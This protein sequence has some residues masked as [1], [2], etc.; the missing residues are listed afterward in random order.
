MVGGQKRRQR[1][2]W[3]QDTHAL[4]VS[5][6]ERNTLGLTE[7][8]STSYC[9][10][11]SLREDLNDSTVGQDIASRDGRV[12]TADFDPSSSH[13]QCLVVYCGKLLC[14]EREENT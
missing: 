11:Q 8:F 7:H 4:A 14:V 5:R 10:H 3:T 13:A 2:Y 1:C 12:H 6:V 9:L